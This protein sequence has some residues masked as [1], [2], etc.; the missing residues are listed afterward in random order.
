MC[1]AE[2]SGNLVSKFGVIVYTTEECKRDR[3]VV[4]AEVVDGFEG[5]VSGCYYSTQ[6]GG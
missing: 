5:Q 2:W 3:D 6:P 1:L 4:M